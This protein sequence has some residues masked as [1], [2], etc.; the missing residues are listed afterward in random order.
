MHMNF[1]ELFHVDP[2]NA[3]KIFGRKTYRRLQKVLDD[4]NAVLSGNLP[5]YARVD[6]DH[7]VMS[8]GGTTF[9]KGDGYKLTIYMS[10]NGIMHG[11]EYIHGYIYGPVIRFEPEVMVGNYP[12]IQQLSFYPGEELNKLLSIRKSK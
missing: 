8:D 1:D 5:I 6:Q 3:S 2:E 7:P 4:F 12:T 11:K 10:L 9:Y